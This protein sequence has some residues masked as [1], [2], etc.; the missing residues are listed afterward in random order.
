LIKKKSGIGWI[1]F[2]ALFVIIIIIVA[3]FTLYEQPSEQKSKVTLTASLDPSKIKVGEN[4]KLTLEFKNQDLESHQITC[5]FK[6]N[7]KIII[8][9][10][11][12]PL[13]NNEYSFIIESSDPTEE[14]IFNVK[15]L[16]EEYVS[17]SEYTI[18][19]SLHLDGT[20]IVEETK[21][22]TISVTES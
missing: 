21:K 16:L 6:A 22:L 2:L 10:G 20:E 17:S 8:Q 14:R 9:S 12:K 4:S 18:N 3:A 7:P 19:V 15:A 1:L 13:V 11:T 5:S